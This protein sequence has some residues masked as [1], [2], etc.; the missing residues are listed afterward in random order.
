MIGCQLDVTAF[1]TTLGPDIQPAFYQ[2]NSAPIQAMNSQFLQEKAVENVDKGFT[3]VQVDKIHSFS[4]ICYEGHLVTQ[5]RHSLFYA[6]ANLRTVQ[7]YG[8]AVTSFLQRHSLRLGAFLVWQYVHVLPGQFAADKLGNMNN[9]IP[10]NLKSEAK[11]AAKILREFTEITS[12]NGPDKIIPPHVIAKAKGLAVLSVI[13]AGFLVT[14]RGGSGIVLARLPNGTWSAPSAIGIA[15]LGG[16]FEIGIEVSDLVIILNHERAVEAFAKGGNLT[17][18]GNLT[19]AIGPLGRNLEGDVAL[20][21]SAA[22]YTYCK[23]RGLFA[24]VSLEGTCLIERKETNRKFYGQDIRASAILLGDVPFPAQA[25]DLYETL[26]SFTEVYENEEQKNNPGNSARE[27]RRV[28]DPPARPSSRPEP[29][30]P[31]IRPT[32]PAKK[33][34]NKL[35]PELPNDYAS[36]D[37]VFS[38][39]ANSAI[40]QQT[41]K[42]EEEF[43]DRKE[44][45]SNYGSGS[46]TSVH[47]KLME[48]I[49]LQAMLRYMENR[50]VIQE[51][52]HGF[53]KD[54]FYLTNSVAFYDGRAVVNGSESKWTSVT[55]GVP[56][57]STIV[58][59]L[60]NISINDEDKRIEYNLIK[61]AHNTKL[62]GAVDKPEGWRATQ[63]DQDKHKNYGEAWQ[64]DYITLPQTH[65]GKHYMLTMVEATTGWLVTYPV[66]HATARNTKKKQTKKQVLWRHSTP[67]GIES[68]KDT[69]FKNGLI[70]T[71]A[72]ERCNGLLKTTFKAWGGGTFKHWELHLAKATWLANTQGSISQAGP[73][74][75]E[76]LNTVDGDKVSVVHMRGMLGKTV[77]ISPTSS[78]GKPI[79]G[80]AFAQ[81]RG[82]TW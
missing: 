79:R 36:V 17:L 70:E 62:S 19:V 33:N 30:K 58:Q 54:T 12:R 67:E 61:F 18:G 73:S 2:G 48:Q 14:A 78:N 5:L 16:G 71:W 28:N 76:L 53:T 13:K 32:P 27:Q 81:G 23:S 55:S 72:G 25:D 59:V 7:F 15:G 24:G 1:P 11:K 22:V 31:T 8:N 49:L 51:S 63:R 80:I 65:Q 57:R 75:S 20:R 26:A 68:D 45:P 46:L 21:S 3:E 66:P 4:L 82:C 74:Q 35:Y 6:F 37:C 34:T 52:Q 40:C 77:W 38:T 47:G 41:Q 9:P 50:E 64:V 44:D 56:Q 10:S 42:D 60:L 69:H 39:P 43:E 29:P